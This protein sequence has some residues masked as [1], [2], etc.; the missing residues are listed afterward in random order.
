MVLV[1]KRGS[2]GKIRMCIDFGK[3]NA[4]TIKDLYS[5][6]RVDDILD[7]LCGAQFFTTLDSF[8]GYYQI[9]KEEQPKEKTL[10]ITYRGMFENNVL[11]FRLCNAPSYGKFAYFT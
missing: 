1:P 11:P 3:L 8:S 9:Q 4:F 6:P 10:C 5:L 2:G 7:T